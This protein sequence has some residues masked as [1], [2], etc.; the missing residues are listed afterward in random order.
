VQHD[1]GTFIGRGGVTL[2]RQAWL[3]DR[4]PR[5][6]LINLHGLGD[7]SSLYPALPEYFVPLGIAVHA[8][9]LRGHGRSGGQRAYLEDWNDYR[10]DLDTF[11]ALVAGRSAER[12]FLHGNSLGGLAVLDYALHHGSRL[13]GVIAAAPALGEVGVPRLLMAAGRILSRVWPRFSLRT[14][15]NLEGI[16][17]DPA[18]VR[19]MVDDP[20]FH[21]VGTARLS[22]EVVAAIERVQRLA[23][24][25]D[26][27]VLLLH[28]G[29]D[30][31]VSPE[32]TRAFF[33]RLTVADREL[34][35]YPDA[36]HALFADLDAPRVLAD[37]RAWIEART[38]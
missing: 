19:A 34:I 13:S 4:P 5:A 26:V 9:D 21:S 15:M 8:F 23:P 7:H 12:P 11:V 17:R 29:A 6:S 18:A 35:E 10:E 22:T 25:L 37:L 38:G 1:T 36:Y 24:S 20:L 30:T 27:P 14:G 2:F 16:S 28:G 31:M 3:P 33:A 32:G